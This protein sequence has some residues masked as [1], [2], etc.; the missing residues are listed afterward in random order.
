MAAVLR[1]ES[2]H[3]AEATIRS[4][5]CAISNSRLLKETPGQAKLRHQ[6]LAKSLRN[7][8]ISNRLTLA[9]PFVRERL[10]RG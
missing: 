10:L 7:S 9:I 3:K 5:A 4:R 8:D 6:T 2:A 1:L